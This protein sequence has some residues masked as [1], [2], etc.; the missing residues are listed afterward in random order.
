MPLTLIN[1]KADIPVVQLS[2]HKSASPTEHFKMG[3][4]LSSLRDSNVAIIGSG[5]PT[6][7]NLRMIFSGATDQTAV[8]R[9]N[10][11]WSETLINT[12]K[13]KDSKEREAKFEGWRDWVGAREAHPEGGEEHFLPLVVCA[14]AAGESQAEGY[15]NELFGM[16]HYTYFWK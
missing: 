4:A 15:G 10:K 16:K 14:G 9:R 8:K 1:P 5:M 6:F 12:L 7:H 3:R 2:V 11:E 13:V